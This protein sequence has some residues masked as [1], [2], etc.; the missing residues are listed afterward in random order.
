MSEEMTPHPLD[1]DLLDYVEETTDSAFAERI[2]AHVAGCPICRVKLDRLR[3]SLPMPLSD[4]PAGVGQV[5]SFEL[6]DVEEAD[7]ADARPGELWLTAS[8]VAT[9]VL[10]RAVRSIGAGF[11]V[12]PV[13]LDVGIGDSSTLVLDSSTSPIGVPIA[14]F[15]RLVTSVPAHGLKG[16]IVPTSEVDLLALTDADPGVSRGLPLEGVTDPRREVRQE[17][18]D[19]LASLTPGPPPAAE[20]S[21]FD[22]SFDIDE[23]RDQLVAWRGESLVVEPLPAL[24]LVAGAASDWVPL[25]R[26]SEFGVR[27]VVIRTPAGLND[28]S[29]VVAARGLL[30]KLD[31]S[32]VVVANEL[33]DMVDVFE[34]SVMFSG[35]DLPE[36]RPRSRPLVADMGL[37]DA[38]VKFLD[39]KVRPAAVFGSSQARAGSVDVAAI[40]ADKVAGTV[41][42]AVRRAPGFKA[43]KREGYRDLERFESGIVDALRAAFQPGFDPSSLTD[44]IDGPER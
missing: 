11:V 41:G 27:L 38:V 42:E 23:L 8:D 22:D 6:I 10:V 3:A 40:L 9:V 33:S 20:R 26:I 16:R 43:D 25:A 34:P 13:V 12:V 44:L 24:P 31:A 17:L 14:I 29:E 35:F 32:A 4:M 21:D 2:S 39:L 28:D 18:V 15:E 37:V 1:T 19:R 5:P 30:V 36:G 7:G